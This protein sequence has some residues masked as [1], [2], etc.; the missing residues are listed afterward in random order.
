[1]ARKRAVLFLIFKTKEMSRSR[2]IKKGAIFDLD[3]TLVSTIGMHEK[4]YHEMFQ[5][6]A[7]ILTDEDLKEQ[8]GKKNALFINGILERKNR[9]DLNP[10]RLSDEKDT[11]VLENLREEPA[12]VFDGV[13]QFLE[14]L[15]G[16]GVKLALATSATQK[17]A[18]ILGREIT[19]LFDVKIFAEDVGHGKP[20]P[21][22]FLKAAERLGLENEDCVIFEDAES[23]IE[24]AKAGGFLCIAK[25]NNLGQDLSKADLVVK[26][27]NSS[28]LIGYFSG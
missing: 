4:A 9:K 7:I 1:M 27:Y 19:P 11:I 28:E 14:L 13:K 5:R 22:I 16:N 21:E 8:S 6:H 12:I 15:K 17:T 25:D 23:G 18:M 20:H 3:G 10:E 24:A 2:L 26:D